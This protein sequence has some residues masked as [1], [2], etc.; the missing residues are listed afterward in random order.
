MLQRETAT[1]QEVEQTYMVRILSKKILLVWIA[2]VL[3]LVVN[4]IV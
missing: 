3:L 1:T 2:S 4:S